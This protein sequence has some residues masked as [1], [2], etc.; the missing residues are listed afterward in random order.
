[1]ALP[2]SYNVRSLLHRKSR[3]ALTVIG[4]AAVIVL[5]VAMVSLFCGR[6]ACPTSIAFDWPTE[7]SGG[8][9]GSATFVQH[10]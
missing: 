9:H 8:S 1:V 3:T 4:I 6:R 5:F 2:L 10:P 7:R